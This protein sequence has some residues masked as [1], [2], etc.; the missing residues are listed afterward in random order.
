[1][2]I[3]I[4]FGLPV[5]AKG[6]QETNDDLRALEEVVARVANICGPWP[7]AHI[8]SKECEYRA[9]KAT[10]INQVLAMREPL[11]HQCF[12]CSGDTCRQRNLVIEERRVCAVAFTTPRRYIA[13]DSTLAVE[14]ASVQVRF[15]Y[16][17][18]GL[19]HVENIAL[20]EVMGISHERA[21]RLVEHGAR[22]VRFVPL[23][24]QGRSVR[25]EAISAG[26]NM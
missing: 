20:Q 13:L 5:L 22:Q 1:M 24:Y 12:A 18:N 9:L 6:A 17:I 26:F 19:G 10:T 7:V 4:V 2:W 3:L 25:L 8:A 11:L 23:I 15:T 14:Q 21:T 16:A